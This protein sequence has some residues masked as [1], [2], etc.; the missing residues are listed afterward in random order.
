LKIKLNL[1]KLKV[2]KKFTIERGRNSVTS[3]ILQ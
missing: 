2:Y 3:K 1:T